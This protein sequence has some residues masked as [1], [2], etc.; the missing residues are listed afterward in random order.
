MEHEIEV[1]E[2]THS[3]RDGGREET[4]TQPGADLEASESF[5]LADIVQ[6]TAVKMPRR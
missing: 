2:P 3:P 6:A 1:R 4:G 5:S